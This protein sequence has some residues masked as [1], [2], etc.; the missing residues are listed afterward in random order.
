MKSLHNNCF[1]N[2]NYRKDCKN[3]FTAEDAKDA[4]ENLMLL[5]FLSVLCG[6]N[7]FS[8]WLL[9]GGTP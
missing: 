1:A 3:F 9:Q 8:L 2:V 7:D 4:E 6:K 5:P